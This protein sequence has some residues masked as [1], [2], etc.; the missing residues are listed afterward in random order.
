MNYEIFEKWWEYFLVIFWAFSRPSNKKLMKY[1][2]VTKEDLKIKYGP[3]ISDV[4]N[5]DDLEKIK[6]LTEFIDN[7]YLEEDERKKTIENKAH[8]LIGQTSLAVSFLLAAIS[9]GST[10]NDNLPLY[11]KIIVWLLFFLIILNFVTAGLH[12]RNVVTALEGFAHHSIEN[13]FYPD[14]SKYNLLFEK[15]FMSEYNFYLNNVKTTY[16]RFSHWYFKFSFIITV[17]VALILPPSIMFVYNQDLEF[18]SPTKT[19]NIKV[20]N[21]YWNK[22]KTNDSISIKEDSIKQKL[23][24]DTLLNKKAAICE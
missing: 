4:L 10:Q 1:E 3:R 22:S 2:Q 13:F 14:N 9:F 12:A 24:D 15:F 5:T 18:E 6:T 7:K 11:F 19:S 16:L 20:E 8:S 23:S 17:I 21:Y